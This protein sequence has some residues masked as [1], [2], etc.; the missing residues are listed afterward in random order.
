M[1]VS[2]TSG[3]FLCLGLAVGVVIVLWMSL[4]NLN[5]IFQEYRDACIEYQKACNET[6]AFYENY[7]SSLSNLTEILIA[8]NTETQKNLT[9]IQTKYNYLKESYIQLSEENSQLREENKNLKAQKGLVNPSY[10]QLLNF[11]I[12]DDTDELEWSEDFDCTEFSNR[13]IKNF[14]KEGFFACTTEISFED[15]RGHIIVAVNTTDKGLRYVEPQDDYIIE[16][17]RLKVGEKYC[18]IVG[19]YCKWN[20]TISKISSCFELKTN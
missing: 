12:R 19:W 9:E 3:C 5:A 15:G 6:I 16:P 4:L 11:I 7:S 2:A 17:A 1:R 13:F 20:D 10:R 14:A 18:E 8:K